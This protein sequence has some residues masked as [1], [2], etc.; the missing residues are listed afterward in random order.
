MHRWIKRT[1]IALLAIGGLGVSVAY[2]GDR[3]GERKRLRH[4]AVAVGPVA[5]GSDAATLARGEYLYRSRGCAECHGADGA[6]RDVIRDASG[7]WIRAPN[8]T[9]VAGGV[10]AR[11]QAADWVRTVRHGVKPDGR[12]VLVMPSEEYS[13][14]ADSDIG[15]LIAHVRA[16]P[17]LAGGGAVIQLPLPVKVLYAAGVVQDAAEKIDHTA[18][19]PARVPGGVTLERGAYVAAGCEGCHGARLSG[20]PVPGAPPSW[21]AAANLTP[22]PGSVLG[23]YPT[24]AAFA[25]MLR[26]GRRPDGSAISPVMPFR[27]LGALDDADTE[28][29]YRYLQQTTPRPAGQR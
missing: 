4:V 11:Y 12:P 25:A 16:L 13:R 17:P 22:G 2:V 6:G 5:I 29:L 15:A 24:V 27:A 28:A 20:G 19:P 26:S 7:L 8:I 1:G 3:L 10:V 9:P 14:L 23:R 18:P 21:P